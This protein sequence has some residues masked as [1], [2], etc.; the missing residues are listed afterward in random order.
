MK[1][2]LGFGRISIQSHP[3]AKLDVQVPDLFSYPYRAASRM[4]RVFN[5]NDLQA[6]SLEVVGQRETAGD[7]P[8]LRVVIRQ[9]I[10]KVLT[11]N[12]KQLHKHQ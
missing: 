2:V 9:I 12:N 4:K 10:T 7:W 5:P 3:P 1:E 8:E 11:P 6:V